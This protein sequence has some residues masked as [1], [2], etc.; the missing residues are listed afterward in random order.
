MH[1]RAF[2]FVVDENSKSPTYTN[3]VILQQPYPQRGRWDDVYGATIMGM[4]IWRKMLTIVCSGSVVS[5]WDAINPANEQLRDREAELSTDPGC[6]WLSA[7][8]MHCEDAAKD[9]DHRFRYGFTQQT[10]TSTKKEKTKKWVY[11]PCFGRFQLVCLL[12][13]DPGWSMSTCY[14]SD[15]YLYIGCGDGSIAMWHSHRP[16]K[17]MVCGT[18]YRQGPVSAI[19]TLGDAVFSGH[20]NAGTKATGGVRF[21]RTCVGL[22]T[23]D[24]G[25]RLLPTMSR[26][27]VTSFSVFGKHVWAGTDKGTLMSFNASGESVRVIKKGNSLIGHPPYFGVLSSAEIPVLVAASNRKLRFWNADGS[28]IS[29]MLLPSKAAE[30]YEGTPCNDVDCKGKAVGIVVHHKM[31]YILL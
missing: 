25:K 9:K 12:E 2:G 8:G 24:M 23:G 10:E 13:G 30:L 14:A 29:S 19:I 3:D 1:G 4:A 26:G 31:V 7:P 22:I 27:G 11:P 28:A 15:P 5:V 6:P 16:S 21:W 20:R 17:P 18:N